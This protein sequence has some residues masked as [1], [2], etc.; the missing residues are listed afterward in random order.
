MKPTKKLSFKLVL[1]FDDQA[2]NSL[3]IEAEARNCISIEKLIENIARALYNETQSGKGIAPVDNLTLNIAII[4]L[5]AK[6]GQKK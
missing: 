6:K 3:S 4:N 2:K 1:E 5:R